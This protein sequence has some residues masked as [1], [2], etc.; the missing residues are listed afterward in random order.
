MQLDQFQYP[1]SRMKMHL[2]QGL[3]QNLHQIAYALYKGCTEIELWGI[4]QGLLTEYAF[5][6][7]CVE[8]WLGM[9]IASGVII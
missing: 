9:A 2:N 8:F 1:L 5:H 3:K 6:K 7:G 4:R